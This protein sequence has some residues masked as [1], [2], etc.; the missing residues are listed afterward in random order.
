MHREQTIGMVVVIF[1]IVVG[2]GLLVTWLLAVENRLDEH[3]D[4]LTNLE[5]E[6]QQAS[7]RLTTLESELRQINQQIATMTGEMDTFNSQMSTE[8]AQLNEQLRVLQMTL[9]VTPTFTH[10]PSPSPSPSNTPLPTPS[11]TPTTVPSATPTVPTPTLEILPRDCEGRVLSDNLV[12]YPFSPNVNGGE[13]ILLHLDQTVG[14]TAI[15]ENGQWYWVY[16]SFEPYVEGYVRASQIELIQ[17]CGNLP[18]FPL[19]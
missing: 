13:R 2:S 9:D 10:T 11:S 5:D 19:E 1:V 16:S 17:P 4:Q 3:N 7:A 14:V 18:T 12:Q 15:S 6:N 8:A